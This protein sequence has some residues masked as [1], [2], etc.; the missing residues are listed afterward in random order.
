MA[1]GIMGSTRN[2]HLL[3]FQATRTAKCAYFDGESATLMGT[4]RMHTQMLHI[5]GNVTGPDP[6]GHFGPGLVQEYDRARG[7]CSWVHERG[8]G[9]KG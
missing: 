3:T 7:L 9:G 6:N 2:S 5:Y 4:G 1:Y 8:L